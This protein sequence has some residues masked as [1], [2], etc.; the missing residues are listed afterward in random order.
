MTVWPLSSG[1]RVTRTTSERSWS[2]YSLSPSNARD[3]G[4]VSAVSSSRSQIC[5]CM[6]GG[7]VN[8][9]GSQWPFK[10]TSRV[11]P[12]IGSPR[13][14][15]SLIRSPASRIPRHLTKPA[16]QSPSD[17]SSPDGTEERN[18]LDVRAANRPA[19]EKLAALKDRLGHPDEDQLFG[20]FQE[21]LLAFVEVPVEP[22]ELV[23][24][25]VGVV[26]P[27]LAMA[28]LVAAQH[29]GHSHRQHQAGHEIAL[30]PLAQL[31][32]LRVVG[33]AFR[34]A[35]PAIVVV[36]AVAVFLAVGVVV[37]FVVADQVVQ[38][39]PVVTGDEIDAGV[40]LAAIV[41]V[42]VAAAGQ[43]RRQL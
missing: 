3:S 2:G 19:D 34:A 43:A 33:R 30:L 8:G 25:A 9:I 24:L 36:G 38:R 40:R 37:L 23:V 41:L 13:S 14:V 42:Q 32:D 1:L 31:D 39:E 22:G 5:P 7:K 21:L 20:E 18:V 4:L 6:V 10:S 15:S 26:V 17:I 35:V 16:F 28:Q 27:L 12:T 29:H 11:S